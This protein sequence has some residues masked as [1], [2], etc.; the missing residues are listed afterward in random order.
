MKNR[1]TL[2]IG[3]LVVLVLLAYMF[4]FQ[5]RYDEVAVRT[6]FDRAEQDDVLNEGDTEEAGLKFRLPPP[7]QRVHT[8]PKRLQ[9]LDDPIEER[10]TKDNY[11][12]LVRTYLAWKIDDPLAFFRTLK[13][14]DNARR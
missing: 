1:L 13:T 7:I 10:L 8:Y 5:V 9:I 3:I 14:V 11:S 4:M 2:V 6:T 12:V